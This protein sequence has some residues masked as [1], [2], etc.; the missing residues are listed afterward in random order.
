MNAGPSETDYYLRHNNYIWRKYRAHCM[1][2]AV[3][4]A[5]H[6]LTTIGNAMSALFDKLNCR[7]T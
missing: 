1:H 3:P 4:V 2:G 6:D 5:K 7:S